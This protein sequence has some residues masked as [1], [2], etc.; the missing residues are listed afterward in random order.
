[1]AR[2]MAG[3]AAAYAR[4]HVGGISQ[5]T[6][7]ADERAISSPGSAPRGSLDILLRDARAGTH[8]SAYPSS[9]P[10]NVYSRC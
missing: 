1:M 2:A 4:R 10:V 8:K 7:E 3:D 9:V 6:D 5:A